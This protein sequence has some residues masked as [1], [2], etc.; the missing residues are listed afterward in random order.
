MNDNYRLSIE[1]GGY[2]KN[3]KLDIV[4]RGKLKSGL[5]VASVKTAVARARLRTMK[6]LIK[7]SLYHEAYF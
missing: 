3:I 4:A 2:D 1:V 7:R 5:L 6:I